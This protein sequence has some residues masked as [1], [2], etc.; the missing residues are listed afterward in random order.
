[1]RKFLLFTISVL[2]FIT[3]AVPV[4]A[5]DYA[6]AVA[7][8]GGLYYGAGSV[9]VMDARTGVVLYETEGFT[10][11]Y[12]ASITKIMTALVVLEQV[13]DLQERITISAN[14]VDLP[15]YAGRMN[16]VAGESITVL[17]ALYGIMLPSA[18]DIARALA[19]HVSGNIP[20]FVAIMNSRAEELG[21]YNT[22]FINP[23][24][25]P[26]Y[27]QFTTAYDMALIKQA[28]IRNPVYNQ[29][30]GTAYFNLPPTNFY[31]ETRLMRNSNMMVRPARDEFN[32]YV[33]GG[34]TGFTNAAQH[35]LVTFATNQEL[36][37]IISVLYASPRGTI[38]TDTAALIDFIFNPPPEPEPP[39]PEPEPAP[40]YIPEE[41]HE[42]PY[43]EQETVPAFAY[44]PQMPINITEAE[45]IEEVSG[46]E[47]VTSATMSI[48]IAVT[49]LFALAL[50]RKKYYN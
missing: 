35:T 42:E 9:L 3:S 17:E 11:R 5:S 6:K 20:D 44:I 25:L 24:G 8:E 48:A 22:R 46:T 49:A 34:K 15:H 23:C 43:D 21:A 2:I 14:A 41:A 27:N 45:T 26:G 38:F 28:A 1:M 31:E 12:P 40:E 47:A 33:V 10:R 13:E 39:K 19:E 37:I 36:S 18:N 50:I 7:R 16:M 29:I 30:I 32:A 4:G